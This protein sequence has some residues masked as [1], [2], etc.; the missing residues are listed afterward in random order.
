[1]E[2][3]RVLWTDRS[4]NGGE[5]PSLVTLVLTC[6]PPCYS[7]AAYGNALHFSLEGKRRCEECRGLV[8]KRAVVTFA[9]TSPRSTRSGLY[10]LEPRFIRLIGESPRVPPRATLMT[11]CACTKGTGQ[12]RA[13]A[14]CVRA[15]RFRPLQK[16][17]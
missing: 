9:F 1:M 17:R 3:A 2:K 13:H 6:Q 7:N 5:R 11:H 12:T 8:E 16:V 14:L 10:R 4:A 15:S